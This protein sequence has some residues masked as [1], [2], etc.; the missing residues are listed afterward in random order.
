MSEWERYKQNRKR[1]PPIITVSD[2]TKKVSTP[3]SPPRPKGCTKCKE[4]DDILKIIQFKINEKRNAS[5]FKQRWTAW[6]DLLDLI[7]EVL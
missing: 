7:E 1:P 2:E 5:Y 6:Q 3:R 4:K